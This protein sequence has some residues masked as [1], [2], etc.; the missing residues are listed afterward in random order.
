MPKYNDTTAGQGMFSSTPPGTP[1][2]TSPHRQITLGRVIILVLVLATIV[3][4]LRALLTPSTG[5]SGN[6]TGSQ[7]PGAAA[8][9]VDHYAPNATLVDLHNN[10]V[11]L[12]SLRGNVVVLN[13]WYVACAPCQYE[14]PALQK[15]YNTEYSRGLVVVGI[16]TSDD[17]TTITKFLKG[18]GIT[19]PVLRDIGQRTTIEYRIVDT[20]TSFIIDR[21]GVIRYKVIGPLDTTTLDHDISSVLAHT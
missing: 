2:A 20:P 1:K 3:I 8:P 14:M 4:L 5:L 9:L 18:L 13:F 12:S 6:T 17:A 10:R 7:V 21:N 16:N 19:Y 15:V 11:A